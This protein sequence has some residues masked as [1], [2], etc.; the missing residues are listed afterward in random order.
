MGGARYARSGGGASGTSL[1]LAIA[2]KGPNVSRM[3]TSR[4]WRR[5][6]AAYAH[7]ACAAAP[8]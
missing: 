6:A 8:P 7:R 3:W 1:L 5:Q 2:S 4:P